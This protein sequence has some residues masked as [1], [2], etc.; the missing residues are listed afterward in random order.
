[1]QAMVIA[2]QVLSSN[3]T[4]TEYENNRDFLSAV[5]GVIFLGTPHRGSSFT[6]LAGLKIGVGKRLLQ[7]KSNEEIV[8]ILKPDS[9][10]LDELQREFAQLCVDERMLDL[11]LVCYY[12]MRDVFLLRTMV[13]SRD[14]ALLDNSDARG[15]DANHMDMNTF[16]EGDNGQRDNNYHHFKSDVQMILHKSQVSVPKRFGNWVYGS[17]TPDP[18]REQ[19]QRKLDASREPQETTYFRKLEIQQSAAYTCHWI[20]DVS[21]FKDWKAG[22]PGHDTLWIYGPA[23][24]GKSV[25]AAYIISSLKHESHIMQD[26]Q[27]MCHNPISSDRCGAEEKSSPVLYFFCGVDRKSETP[28]RML[29]TLIHQLLLARSESQELFNIGKEL[30]QK[31]VSGGASSKDFAEALKKMAS[32]VGE[33]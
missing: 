4:R 14:S 2:S 25:L 17:S 3:S 5:A 24:S 20:H 8:S 26:R 11:K 28:E 31:L 21:A 1:M 13:V 18:E 19:L 32:K 16:Y 33:L 9:Y 6:L 15:M 22:T 27:S 30:C 29:A 23:G 10:T 7:V 12:E